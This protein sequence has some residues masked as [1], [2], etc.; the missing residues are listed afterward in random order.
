MTGGPIE[1]KAYAAP[2]A[3]FIA[4]Q[5]LWAV[6]TFWP[7]AADAVTPDQR[8]FLIGAVATV[9]TAA[10]GYFAPHTH[11]P[12]LAAPVPV[13]AEYPPNKPGPNVS[14]KGALAPG[15]VPPA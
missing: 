5:A 13:P 15:E 11:R 3:T 10:A 6:F 14:P 2:A 9:L 7:A 1:N 12:D 8:L 4:T